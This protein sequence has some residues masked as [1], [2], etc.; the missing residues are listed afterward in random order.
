MKRLITFLIFLS[1]FCTSK[2]VGYNDHRGYNIDSLE[3]VAAAWTPLMIESATDEQ[4]QEYDLTW[5]AL[6][7]G[8]LNIN[9]KKSEYYARKILSSIKGKGWYLSEF[10]P[11][12]I[13]GQCFW[14]SEQYDSATFYYKKALDLTL[15]MS[16]EEINP[17]TNKQFTEI[18]IDDSKSSLLGAIGNLFSIQDMIDSAMVYYDN[19][20]DIFKRHGWLNSCSVLYYNMGET[21]LGAGELSKAEGCYHEALDYAKQ[22]ND[23]L[24][25][26]TSLKG[27]GGLYLGKGR[28]TKALKCLK[29]ADKYYSIHEDEELRDRLETVDFMGQVLSQQKKNLTLVLVALAFILILAGAVVTIARRLHKA[30]IEK[31][32]VAEFIEETIAEAPVL[33][34]IKLN[35]REVAIL[36]MLSEGKETAEMADTLC[37]SPETIKWYRKRLLAKFD[38]SSAAALVAEAIKRG[39]IL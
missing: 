17:A 29:E 31:E 20:G 24:W 21:W 6:M 27:L 9:S 13:L 37:L 36:K 25:I 16:S 8:N 33:P 2:A 38:V 35:D 7:D 5:R 28:T 30:N 19:A 4:L 32:E 34:E 1:V 14:A 22:A 12:K 26:A 10:Y 11:C 39:V 23:S 3:R 15:K 18:D